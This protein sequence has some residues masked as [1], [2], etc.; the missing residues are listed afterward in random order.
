LVYGGFKLSMVS[1]MLW[2]IVTV[3]G[4]AMVVHIIV[5]FREERGRGFSPKSALLRCGAFLA[6][7]IMWVCFTDA[8]GFISLLAA[9]VGPVHDFGVMMAIGSLLALVSVSVVLPTL[10]LVGSVDADPRQAWGEE[11][12]S[13]GLEW[14]VRFIERWP[15]AIGITTIAI[16]SFAWLGYIWLDVETDFTRNFRQSSPIVKSYAVV[17]SRLGGGGVWDILLPVPQQIDH[18]LLDRVRKLEDRLRTEIV[19]PDANGQAT[20]G[21]TKILSVTDAL[22]TVSTR[23]LRQ[24]TD[25]E[26]L[27]GLFRA[28]MPAVMNALV[29]TDPESKQRTLRIMLRARERQPAAQKN[30]LIER[31]TEITREEFPEGQVTGFFI[32]LTNLIDSMLRDQ[33]VSFTIATAAIAVM[34]YIAF[35]RVSLAL[36]AMVPNALPITV[37]TGLMG[38]LGIGINMGA[39]MIA[40]VSM[41]QAVDS[42]I[43]YITEYLAH[44]REGLPLQQALLAVQQRAGRA[45]VFSTLAMCVGFSALCLSQFVPLIY[46]GVLMSLSM[47]GGLIGNLVLLPL[48]LRWAARWEKTPVALVKEDLLPATVER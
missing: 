31:V 12:L 39:A 30:Y 34:M 43:H 19:V 46:F 47:L 40:A 11:N 2:A 13:S 27:L 15:R 8:A 45:A 5:E 7:P 48:L 20:P 9:K 24:L 14:L 6:V 17:E 42:S 3:I 10:A 18:A 1:S 44:R 38:W 36:I 28:Q 22:D 33:W 29:G 16:V 26:D 37:I 35:Q 41:G 32:L 4:I 21:L 25:P 23:E